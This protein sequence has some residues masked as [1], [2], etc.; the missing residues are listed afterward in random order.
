[1]CLYGWDAHR[2]HY[3][4]VPVCR[5]RSNRSEGYTARLLWH[6]RWW[7]VLPAVLSQLV[8]ARLWHDID[9]KFTGYV[10]QRHV[11]DV[12]FGVA[13]I[14]IAAGGAPTA[15]HEI[16]CRFVGTLV[17]LSKKMHKNVKFPGNRGGRKI[18]SIFTGG[19]CY[20]KTDIY[21]VQSHATATQTETPNH[22]TIW[23]CDVH[24]LV[25]L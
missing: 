18:Q 1:M 16:S 8:N 13:V 21:S 22:P 25:A 3:R 4:P 2:R 9:R 14:G 19:G 20:H 17:W 12:S 24:L 10:P 5:V 15:R 6:G 23:P 11:E 7:F